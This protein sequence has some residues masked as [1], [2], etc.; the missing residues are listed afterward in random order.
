MLILHVESAQPIQSKV[1]DSGTEV[2]L[3]QPSV[4]LDVI[5]GLYRSVGHAFYLSKLPPLIFAGVLKDR[6]INVPISG[7][8]SDRASLYQ[9]P[10]Q[11]IESTSQILSNI[12]DDRREL[13]RYSFVHSE[14]V[15][16]LSRQRVVLGDDFVGT[17]W[18]EK[19][20]D[21]KLQI[22]E[23]LACSIDFD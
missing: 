9:V 5:N 21:L 19:S 14:I 6:E 1:S 10:S 3:V 12:A 2:I 8:R 17:G 13:A 22:D 4:W 18:I 20:L 16:S 15:S 11:V 23:M 7:L